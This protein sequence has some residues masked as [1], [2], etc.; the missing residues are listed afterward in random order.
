M[1]QITKFVCI[2]FQTILVQMLR[3]LQA[4]L[5]IIRHNKEKCQNMVF[6]HCV[7][8]TL[9]HAEP[10]LLG[11][12]YG[13]PKPPKEPLPS[14]ALRRTGSLG[15]L[16]GKHASSPG[17]RRRNR[18]NVDADAPPT[19]PASALAQPVAAAR[20]PSFDRSYSAPVDTLPDNWEMSR[21]DDGTPYFIE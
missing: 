4:P 18:S 3:V 8:M 9:P 5:F 20:R 14:S 7:I 16:G 21:T 2:H 1:L 17:K 15:A 12:H 13:T 10:L 6:Q 19:R 11:N